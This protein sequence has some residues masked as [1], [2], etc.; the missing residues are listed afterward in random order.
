MFLSALMHRDVPKRTNFGLFS[1]IPEEKQVL[2]FSRHMATEL[3]S[4]IRAG[5]E[6]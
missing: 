5:K 6:S 3:S 1:I 2:P 4:K